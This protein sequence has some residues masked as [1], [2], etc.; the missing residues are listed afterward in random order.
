MDG[1]TD[2]YSLGAILYELLT[3]VPVFQGDTVLDTL[4][5]VM[6]VEP[7]PPCKLRPD[8]PRDLEAICLKC[9]EKDP[10]ARYPS[11]FELATDLR[12][13]RSHEPTRV[14]PLNGAERLARWCRRKPALAG[15]TGLL[16]TALF[17]LLAHILWSHGRLQQLVIESNEG[18]QRAEYHE[19]LA[20]QNKEWALRHERAAETMA[21]AADLRLV[22]ESW[23]TSCAP[24]ITGLLQAHVPSAG[25]PDLRGFEWW[26]YHNLL[27]VDT[28]SKE[29]GT[30]QG[31]VTIDRG[32]PEGRS[33]GEWR[34]GRN[35]AF[36]ALS[37][38]RR[39]A[40]CAD[41][42]KTISAVSTSV[43]TVPGSR[44]RE[45]TRPSESGMFETRK[46]LVCL[47][48][49]SGWV[50]TVTFVSDNATLASGGQDRTVIVWDSKSG[51]VL[52]RLSGHTDTV[53][54]LAFQRRNR[55]LFSAAEDGTVRAWDLE[56]GS[57]S[58][59]VPNGLLENP[60]R[61]WIRCLALDTEEN[62]LLGV[63]FA[64]QPEIV[65]D[66][67][68]GHTGEIHRQK[69]AGNARCA[70]IQGAAN[71][72]LVAFGSED[73]YIRVR[74]YGSPYDMRVLRG[75][76]QT[77]DTVAL[78]SR[79]E[80]SRFGLARRRCAAVESA[81]VRP[82]GAEARTRGTSVHG[83]ARPK[84][85]T[86]GSR[87]VRRRN[88]TVRLQD[89]EFDSPNPRPGG[90]P[91]GIAFS[92]DSATL[93]VLAQH[94]PL[95]LYSSAERP[96]EIPV[97]D[98]SSNDRISFSPNGRL[99]AIG[100]PLALIVVDVTRRTV[101]ARRPHKTP[102][103]NIAFLDD[104]TV[105]TS[106]LGGDL[107]RW[108]LRDKREQTCVPMHAGELHQIAISPDHQYGAVRGFHQV[109]IF[110]PATLGV[111]ASLPDHG[112]C[113]SLCFLAGGR[114]LLIGDELARPCLWQT[115]SWHR[116]GLLETDSIFEAE[117]SS[118]GY[119]LVGARGKQLTAIDAR[120]T[121]GADRLSGKD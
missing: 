119:R 106:S 38:G 42:R 30:H 78:S 108:S 12:R 41:M 6:T 114:T 26:F 71:D 65:W 88:A 87:H 37:H 57:R 100:D 81:P 17:A 27:N 52:R 95:R 58:K 90:L 118:D 80:C 48:G 59:L 54:S 50:S 60:G 116:M 84:R 32:Q 83:G 76:S 120:P 109:K 24:A 44:R 63:P 20:D 45:T 86:R 110:N 49:H 8:L 99:I 1:A 101:V 19:R 64:D 105:L 103:R 61:F 102:L 112:Q 7:I 3:G 121:A 47:R 92:P 96:L 115:S 74:R 98:R 33:G 9:L 40:N 5:R 89:F 11:A 93:A 107:C 28:P 111:I 70:S 2:V 73:S 35:R 68:P 79:W 82:R 39:P 31:G 91:S 72:P 117:A 22:A 113:G 66:L 104:S 56:T 69:V 16:A 67:R 34:H 13:F 51:K 55:V 14:R 62:T 23:E 4:R 10:K 77:V 46:Q 94:E 97:P 18:R 53:R 75:H 29:L 21:Y 15:L 36:V 43:R 85:H 25:S